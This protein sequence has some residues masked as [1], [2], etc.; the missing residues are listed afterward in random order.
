M[1]E[2]LRICR[3]C[4]RTDSDASAGDCWWVEPDFCNKCFL[5]LLRLGIDL[6]EG[7]TQYE[8]L[9]DTANNRANPRSRKIKHVREQT[10]R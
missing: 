5:S 4:R 1:R 10:L 7:A 6:V 2:D 9:R 8:S 3:V